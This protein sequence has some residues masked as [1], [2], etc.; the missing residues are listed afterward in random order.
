MSIY[1]IMAKGGTAPSTTY[2]LMAKGGTPHLPSFGANT[3]YMYVSSWTLVEG[4]YIHFPFSTC[5]T[6]N[7]YLLVSMVQE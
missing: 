6:I 5:T 3:V 1:E 2:K 4:L 7:Y